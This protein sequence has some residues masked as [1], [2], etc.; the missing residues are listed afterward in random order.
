MRK[1]SQ[2]SFSAVHAFR[3]DMC[4]RGNIL[5]ALRRA[6]KGS[7]T[8]PRPRPGRWRRRRPCSCSSERATQLFLGGRKRGK[9]PLVELSTADGRTDGRTDGPPL[10]VT[11]CR[12]GETSV[13]CMQ[14]VKKWYFHIFES[15]ECSWKGRGTEK[16]TI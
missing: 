6:G 7:R 16:V 11:S 10:T 12:R 5:T 13:N 9:L 3:F 8:R 14:S 1:M 4:A 2:P 15:Y